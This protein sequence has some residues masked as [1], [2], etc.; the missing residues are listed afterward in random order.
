MEISFDVEKL[1][2]I[3]DRVQLKI[4]NAPRLRAAFNVSEVNCTFRLPVSLVNTLS[5]DSLEAIIDLKDLPG[6]RHKI[7]PEIIGLP[8]HARLIKVDTVLVNF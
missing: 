1:M 6:G 5:L 3:N 8:E 7:V 4:I 2:E